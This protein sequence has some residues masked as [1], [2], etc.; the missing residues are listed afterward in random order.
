MKG[1][2]EDEGHEHLQV[3]ACHDLLCFCDDRQLLCK[4]GKSQKTKVR[5]FTARQEDSGIIAMHKVSL[6][7]IV[8]EKNSHNSVFDGDNI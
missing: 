3:Q 2:K 7:D 1:E 8:Q 6:C 4:Q 5:R